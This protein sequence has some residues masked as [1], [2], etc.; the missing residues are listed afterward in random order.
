MNDKKFLNEEKFQKNKKKVII[1][2]I[3]VLILGFLIGGGLIATGLIR[4]NKVNLKYS[5]ESKEKLSEQLENEKQ[6]ILDQMEDEKQNLINSKTMLETKI[7]PTEEEIKRLERENFTG[8]DDAYYARKDKIEE[9]RKSIAN[10]KDSI[11]LINDIL[12]KDSDECY[13]A[14]EINNT[15]TS[16]YCTLKKEL[17]EK[18]DEISELDKKFDSVNKVPELIPSIIL[19]V[20]G[21]FIIT[22]SISTASFIYIIAKGR[23]I[24]AFTAQQTIPV[25]KGIVETMAP[26]Y[27]KVAKEISKGIKEGLKDDKE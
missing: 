17:N 5:N 15:Y 1:F 19:Y 20:L 22:G 14:K 6:K 27:G 26:T 11:S 24:I 4:Q 10:D 23:D 18:E 2:A 25:K 7:K 12:N 3:L 16:T 13:G 21:A 8:F 9:L